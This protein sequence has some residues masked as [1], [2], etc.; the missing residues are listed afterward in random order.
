MSDLLETLAIETGELQS[1]FKRFTDEYKNQQ[2]QQNSG[3]PVNT[4]IL[5]FYKDKIA[6]KMKVIDDI[7][8][9]CNY[10]LLVINSVK[11]CQE[12]KQRI[13]VIKSEQDQTNVE[14]KVI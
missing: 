2:F 8:Q 13:K 6:I 12:A 10:I 1:L 9:A 5:K 7:S 14:V 11:K 3:Q 4:Q